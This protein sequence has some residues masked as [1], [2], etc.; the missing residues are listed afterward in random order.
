M[1]MFSKELFGFLLKVIT[2]WQVIAV[3]VV[4][5]VYFSLVSYVARLYHPRPSNFSFSSKPKKEK[6]AAVQMPETSEDENLGLEE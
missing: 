6:K 4:L 1:K 2:S 3:S 5:I